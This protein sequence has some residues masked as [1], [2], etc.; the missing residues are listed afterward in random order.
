MTADPEAGVG[1]RPDAG[2]PPVRL[3]GIRF[4]WGLN[5]FADQPVAVAR[6][7]SG[8]ETR[9]PPPVPI[10]LAGRVA[11]HLARQALAMP[12]ADDVV[13]LVRG[14]ADAALARCGA[15]DSRGV[16]LRPAMAGPWDVVVP[17]DHSDT[18]EA[19]LRMAAGLVAAAG[20]AADGDAIDAALAARL[21]ALARGWTGWRPD[22]EQGEIIATCRRLGVR[23]KR[24]SYYPDCI[25]LGEGRR[26][27][28]LLTT[29]TG[30]TGHIAVRIS[31]D[32][33]LT[34]LRLA[35]Q[36]VPVPRHRI[37]QTPA[38]AERAAAEHGY[39]AVVKP[40]DGRWNQGVAVVYADDQVA[41]AFAAAQDKGGGGVVVEKWIA[42][43]EFRI[44]V[45]ADGVCGVHER[46]AP[47]V[48]G[49]G[50]ATVAELIRRANADPAQVDP[51]DAW[52]GPIVLLPIVER[53]LAWQGLGLDRVPEAGRR[54]LVNPLPFRK[55]GGT[56]RDVSDA[57]HPE[58]ATLAVRI[59]RLLELDIAGIDIRLADIARPWTEGP[60]GVCEV[61]AGPGIDNI[62]V[63]GRKRGVD[64][65][66]RMIDRIHPPERRRP[67][68]FVL[69]A[70]APGD[71]GPARARAGELAAALE[72]RFGWTVAV[73]DPAGV[74]LAGGRLRIPREHGARWAVELIL[75]SPE[76]D[77]AVLVMPQSLLVAHGIGHDRID[78]ALL[79][80]SPWRTRL[81]EVLESAG[82][83]VLPFRSEVPEVLEAL[84]GS[85]ARP[86]EIDD[87]TRSGHRH[88][89]GE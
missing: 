2:P 48:L 10:E 16:R 79:A 47:S 18:A 61:N 58:N 24:L 21:S 69:Y 6:L 50:R 78:V 51:A 1:E 62:A 57:V 82:T 19:A 85:S 41:E 11:A 83:R 45:A 9:T 12:A 29:V 40:R 80:D 60:A 70:V 26:Q 37:V 84:A 52:S 81:A 15:P 64:V 42:G 63:T 86:A 66:G 28:R 33:S 75:E 74:A 8:P 72:A 22:V 49:D 73:A 27:K 56:Y 14:I 46:E 32:K 25:Q 53:C 67:L 76:A 59:A 44:L 71:E 7:A 68:P 20:G 4:L 65:P 38:E 43:R 13:S 17:L 34:N 30:E 3:A 36:G 5:V 54:V 89:L 23:W 35:Q 87:S 77:A 39:P 88:R 55:Y 31:N